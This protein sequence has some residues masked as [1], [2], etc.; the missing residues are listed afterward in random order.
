MCV[1]LEIKFTGFQNMTKDMQNLD[2]ELDIKMISKFD[3]CVS[4]FFS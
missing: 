4:I 3:E 2:C 1:D